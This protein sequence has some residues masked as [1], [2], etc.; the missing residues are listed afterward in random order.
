MALAPSG[1]RLKLLNTQFT[2]QLVEGEAEKRVLGSVEELRAVLSGEFG[3][4]LPA[5]E[6][7]EPVL[8]ALVQPQATV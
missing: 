8:A 2:R 3:I 7:L 6:R 4:T 5:D 1:A